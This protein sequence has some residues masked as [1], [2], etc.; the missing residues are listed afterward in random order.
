MYN[1]AGIVLKELPVAANHGYTRFMVDDLPSGLYLCKLVCGR[2]T[3]DAVK[4]I[5]T[6]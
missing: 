4:L 3:L 2:E 5:I 1:N 6:K